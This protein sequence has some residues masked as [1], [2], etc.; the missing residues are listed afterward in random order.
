VPT[1]LVVDDQSVNRDLVRTVLSY[2]GYDVTEA[3]KDRLRCAWCATRGRWL[4][5]G[6]TP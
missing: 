2:S 1:V 3:D 4:P 6:T 5:I